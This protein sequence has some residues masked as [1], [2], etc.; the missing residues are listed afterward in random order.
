MNSL[1]FMWSICKPFLVNVLIANLILLLFFLLLLI[2]K[3]ETTFT[4][5]YDANLLFPSGLILSI[6]YLCDFYIQTVHAYVKCPIKVR[7]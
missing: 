6:C 1:K 3:C 4:L 2:P 5:T 7:I